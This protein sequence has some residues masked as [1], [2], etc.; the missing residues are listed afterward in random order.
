MAVEEKGTFTTGKVLLAGVTA[1]GLAAFIS[2]LVS[3]ARAAPPE[4]PIVSPDEWT[5][6]SIIAMLAAWGEISTKLDDQK[7]LL[8]QIRDGIYTLTGEEI[9]KP[10]IYSLE[11]IPI[12]PTLIPGLTPKSLYLS[13]SPEKGALVAIVLVSD[14]QYVQ[15]DL[16]LDDVVWSFNVADMIEQSIEYP[17]F[18]GAWIATATGSLFVLMFSS[19]AMD[20][21]YK[22]NLRLQAKAT[23]ATDVNI[24]RGELV[25]KVYE[26]RE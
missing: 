16:H 2:W 5:K 1:G 17:H 14:S 23:S 25:R 22:T 3:E 19:G 12:T 11:V 4:G 6:E 15:Y 24:T 13:E 8:T 9:P 21:P 20:V 26:V 18:P 10:E 7:E